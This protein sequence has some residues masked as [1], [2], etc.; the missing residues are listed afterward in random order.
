MRK[1]EYRCQAFGLVFGVLRVSD[2][3]GQTFRPISDAQ[4]EFFAEGLIPGNMESLYS[5]S[6]RLT[7]VPKRLPLTSS[8]K[9]SVA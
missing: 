9:T 4:G 1:R 2:L 3:N 8:T 6:S 5:N 7:C